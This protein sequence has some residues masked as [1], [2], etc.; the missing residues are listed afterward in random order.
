MVFGGINVQQPT[1]Q[2]DPS[3]ADQ[4][5]HT[6]SQDLFVL[7]VCTLS[8]STPVVTGTA[9]SARAGH[10]AVSYGNYMLVMMGKKK[11]QMGWMDN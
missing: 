6:V 11:S 3:E 8:W 4:S 5:G 9:P 10:E 2:N 1:D 7:D